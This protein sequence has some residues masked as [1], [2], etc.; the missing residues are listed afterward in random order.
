VDYRSFKSRSMA[1][2]TLV[3]A[4][5]VI[6]FAATAPTQADTIRQESSSTSSHKR[7][8]NVIPQDGSVLSPGTTSAPRSAPTHLARGPTTQ[9]R[10]A[11]NLIRLIDPN[12]CGNSGISN[13]VAGKRTTS[14]R[15]STFSTDDQE[16]GECCDALSPLTSC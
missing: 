5:G 15:W 10:T 4:I 2:G 12:G 7:A 13:F 9:I 1:A 14:A 6:V 11:I 8:A 3:L 16:M